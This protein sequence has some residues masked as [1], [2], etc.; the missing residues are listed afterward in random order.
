MAA[1][2]FNAESK[3]AEDIES[4]L[5]AFTP[6]ESFKSYFMYSIE[7]DNTT[8]ER[9]LLVGILRATLVDVRPENPEAHVD[10]ME[11]A[12]KW[13]MTVDYE[14]SDQHFGFDQICQELNL[15]S[16]RVRRGFLA[17]LAKSL[18]QI[19]CNQARSKVLIG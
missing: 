12:R 11:D 5:E 7:G 1:F 2:L 8:P 9:S 10:A 15:D 18:N 14:G 17:E 4:E 13:I 3:E 16:E 6:S 19:K